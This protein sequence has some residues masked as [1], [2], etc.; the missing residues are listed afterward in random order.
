MGQL[1][2]EVYLYQMLTVILNY[3]LIWKSY[4]V[5][6]YQSIRKIEQK[7]NYVEMGM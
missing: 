1:V 6:R 3:K 5:S 2:S 4:Y 7:E